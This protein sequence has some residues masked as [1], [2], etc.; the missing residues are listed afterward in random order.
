VVLLAQ[1]AAVVDPGSRCLGFTT[2]LLVS[3]VLLLL[4]L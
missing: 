4:L 2:L 3:K 1:E